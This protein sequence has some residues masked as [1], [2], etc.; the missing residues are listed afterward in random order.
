M[1]TSLPTTPASETLSG[2]ANALAGNAA[3]ADGLAALFALAAPA[4]GAAPDAT[5]LGADASAFTTLLDGSAAP[6]MPCPAPGAPAGA[7]SV[8]PT[9]P[10]N[11]PASPFAP[12]A[13]VPRAVA[14]TPLVADAAATTS[15]TDVRGFAFVAA[16]KPTPVAASTT[17]VADDAGDAAPEIAAPTL[18][19]RSTLEALVALLL[20]VAAAVTPEQPVPMAGIERASSADAEPAVAA[21][22]A[23]LPSRAQIAIAS[24]GRPAVAL[25]ETLSPVPSRV[26]RS[27][28]SAAEPQT[29]ATPSDA[30]ASSARGAALS[31]IA[32]T[33]PNA[34]TPELASVAI[35]PPTRS[36][37]V[38]K[39]S[40][41]PAAVPASP[42]AEADASVALEVSASV[43][44]PDGAVVTLALPEAPARV[45][46]RANV[47]AASAAAVPARPE[48]S[49]AAAAKKNPANFAPESVAGK[50]FL[51]TEEQQLKPAREEAGIGVA[52]TRPTMLF[53][54]HDT[55]SAAHPVVPALVSM[56]SAAPQVAAAGAP[57]SE[58]MPPLVAASVAHRAVEAVTSVVDA[59]AASKLQPVPS[60]QLKFKFGA[61]D[62]AVRVALRDG[63]VTT[64]FRTDSAELRAAIQ[65]EWRAVTAQPESALRYLEPVVAPASP[66]QSG[67]NSF[68]QQQ[69]QQSPGQ[70]AA[71]QQQQQQHQQS[72][73]AAEVFGSVAR[74][75]PF[76][77][78]D[79]GAAS[80]VAPIALPT[81]VHLSAVA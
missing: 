37:A 21:G 7:V 2:A 25:D 10:A 19:D 4:N 64:E 22:M 6:A 44:L 39:A 51:S 47:A 41:Q 70:S 17:P 63:V 62:L 14:P 29:A 20:P 8:V 43:E 27:Q 28:I 5:S 30:S 61:E 31:S 42:E 60:V 3:R 55:L 50:N 35:A 66:A 71:Q 75:T 67:T 76:Q 81:S 58:P 48:K 73:A 72:R 33:T 77:P 9:T 56:V 49:A 40:S 11:V 34:A 52:E 69:H 45:T 15:T 78:R 16:A 65:N 54:P 32:A 74:S 38:E 59:Q 80:N 24:P 46:A 12:T 79:G 36:R 1:T 26:E 68:A 13:P 53:T 23:E 18:P 57:E